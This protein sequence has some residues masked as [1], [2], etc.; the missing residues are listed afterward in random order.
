MSKTEE[1]VR[2]VIEN[3]TSREKPNMIWRRKNFQVPV[4]LI[5]FPVNP[6][7]QVHVLFPAVVL[8]M[9]CVWQPPLF[10][11]HTP[12]ISMSIQHIPL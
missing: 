12:P 3:N 11:A 5:P 8:H 1:H 9:A 6:D 2:R 7:W 10:V 4:Q